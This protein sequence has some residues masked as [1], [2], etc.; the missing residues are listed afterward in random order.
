MHQ[1]NLLHSLLEQRQATSLADEQVSPLHKHN[2]SE[3]GR[4][5]SQKQSLTL[6]EALHRKNITKS[7]SLYYLKQLGKKE[8]HHK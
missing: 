5:C 7:I 8:P 4:L 2:G 3:E 6:Q 1:Q